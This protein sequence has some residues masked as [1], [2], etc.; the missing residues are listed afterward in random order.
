MRSHL[1]LTKAT[2]HSFLQGDKKIIDHYRAIAHE[3]FVD[4]VKS[5]YTEDEMKLIAISRDRLRSI[6]VVC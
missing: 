1:A 4:V 2:S 5:I 6:V 3:L